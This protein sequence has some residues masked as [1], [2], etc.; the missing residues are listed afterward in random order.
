MA[1]IAGAQYHWVSEFAPE[2]YQRILS[3][4]TGWMSTLAYQSGNAHGIFVVGSII[5][6]MIIVNDESYMAPAWQCTLLALA[7]VLLAYAGNVHGARILP[8]WQNAVFT[9]HVLG[10]FA[11]IIPI[12]VKAPAATHHQVWA[13]FTNDGGWSSLGLAILVGQLTRISAQVGV[14]TV[15]VLTRVAATT[16]N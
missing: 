8:H 14:D 16:S 5:Q 3:Y 4:F 6:T 9:V 1:P 12:C 2:G 10:Y 13:E 11:F 15:S 7:A